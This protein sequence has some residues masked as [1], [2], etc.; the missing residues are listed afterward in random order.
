MGYWNSSSS[1]FQRLNSLATRCSSS[2][3]LVL[4]LWNVFQPSKTCRGNSTAWNLPGASN[5]AVFFCWMSLFFFFSPRWALNCA[6]PPCC[7][8]GWINKRP[9]MSLKVFT[10]STVAPHNY[11]G[12]PRC[13][14]IFWS[15]LKQSGFWGF[16]VFKNWEFH[17]WTSYRFLGNHF[18][19]CDYFAVKWFLSEVCGI[20]P[21][22]LGSACKQRCSVE[23][24]ISVVNSV[25]FSNQFQRTR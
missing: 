20:M 8:L 10:H 14:C 11:A 19:V 17:L 25:K 22:C 12:R 7:S 9:T 24:T 4:L 5:L 15:E 18:G 23:A 2:L 1:P 6:Q 16:F 21:S 13:V 3:L